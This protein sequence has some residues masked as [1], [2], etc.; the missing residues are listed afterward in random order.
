MFFNLLPFVFLGATFVNAYIKKQHPLYKFVKDKKLRGATITT[1]QLH[2]QAAG[3]SPAYVTE[4]HYANT[5]CSGNPESYVVSD[6]STCVT[7]GTDSYSIR[8]SE[9]QPESGCSVDFV[10]YS[11]T[12]TCTGAGTI[13]QTYAFTGGCQPGGDSS[14]D[15]NDVGT[16]GIMTCTASNPGI[17]TGVDLSNSVTELFY[18]ES[19]TCLAS[20][21]LDTIWYNMDICFTIASTNEDSNSGVYQSGKFTKSATVATYTSFSDTTC[22]TA[23]ATGTVNLG[24]CIDDSGGGDTV[25]YFTFS[26]TV[27]PTAAPTVAPT[28]APTVASTAAP[29][30]GASV[31][32]HVSIGVSVLL[33][34]V[35]T[36]YI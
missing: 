24:E 20:N 26:S 30:D 5:D 27:A 10:V 11:G 4:T 25:S 12:T 1:K 35:N 17:P 3:T 23:A 21:N 22:T 29:T 33:I 8:N 7:D 2:L 19:A 13:V 36:F 6:G 18:L 34:A 31:A 16:S 9:A 15:F 32:W 28:A 14:G